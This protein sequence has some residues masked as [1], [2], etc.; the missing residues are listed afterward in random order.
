MDV[1]KVVLVLFL[2]CN[3]ALLFAQEET[4]FDAQPRLKAWMA[5][6]LENAKKGK[7]EVVEFPMAVRSAAWGCRCPY[8][9]MGITP[10][11]AEGPWILPLEPKGFPKSD[12]KGHSLIVVGYF[13]GKKI[14]KDYRINKEK[15]PKAW[16]YEMPEFK[17]VSWRKNT[18]DYNVG[19]PKIL[20]SK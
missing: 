14:T 20:K 11:V 15:E 12:E 19:G 9:Y 10:S 1:V 3:N 8:H 17:I 16:V 4:Y 5:E 6:R 2:L 13:T 18:K 7:K